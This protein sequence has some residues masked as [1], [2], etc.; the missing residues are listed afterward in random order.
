MALSRRALIKA[1]AVTAAAA[2]AGITLPAA[3][4]NHRLPDG[5]VVL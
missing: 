2:A 5:Q 1:Q 3:A 4:Q